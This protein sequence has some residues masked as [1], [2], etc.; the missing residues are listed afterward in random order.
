MTAGN[1]GLRPD[2]LLE[3]YLDLFTLE[4]LK[5]P[6][7]DLACGD[8]HNGI[9]L[10]LR[11]LPVILADRSEREV[12]SSMRHLQSTSA[13]SENREIPIICLNQM[14][15]STGLGTCISFIILKA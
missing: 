9:F 14:N 13:N 3:R 11:G 15:Y 1:K 6:I 12:S 7:L 10:A 5:G 4:A 2:L 8:G